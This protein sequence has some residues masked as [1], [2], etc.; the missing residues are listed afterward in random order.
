MKT[1]L[2]FMVALLAMCYKS[3]AC[4]I[5]GCAAGSNYLGILPQ[6]QKHFFGFRYKFNNYQSIH[7]DEGGIGRD[8]FHTGEIWGRFAIYPRLHLYGIVPFQFQKRAEDGSTNWL[9]ELGDATLIANYLIV[10][11]SRSESHKFKST[12]QIG[13]GFKLPTGKND[14]IQDFHTLPENLQPGSGTLD[15]LLNAVYTA[16]Y[17]RLGLNADVAYKING[18]NDSQYK[19]GNRFNTSFRIFMWNQF[20]SLVALPH[21]GLDYE[22]SASDLK[23]KKDVA[24]TGGKSLLAGAGVDLYFKNFSAGVRLQRAVYQHLN[25]GS[26]SENWRVGAQLIYLF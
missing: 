3:H 26:T 23:Y 16:R 8:Y 22:S 9:S 7:P 24:F 11:N 14:V 21:L 5:C 10:D 15:Y 25:Q 18:S 17:K 13:G 1:R 12:I 6:Y 20:K 19:R 4:D 2:F